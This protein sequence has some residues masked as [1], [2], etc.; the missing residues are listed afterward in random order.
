VAA[1]DAAA[2]LARADG[3]L[4]SAG[5][6]PGHPSLYAGEGDDGRG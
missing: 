5:I 1:S 2:R 3:E 6:G 4:A